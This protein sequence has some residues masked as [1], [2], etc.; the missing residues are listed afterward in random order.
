MWAAGP[1]PMMTIWECILRRLG[2]GT[3]E[4]EMGAGGGFPA[5]KGSFWQRAVAAT[6]G[7][8]TE[9]RR[10]EGKAARRKA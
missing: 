4:V 5:V 8:A 3:E 2:V 6:R 9:A 1:E 7:K 10:G